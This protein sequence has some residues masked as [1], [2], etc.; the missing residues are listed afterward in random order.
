MSALDNHDPRR[1]DRFLMAEVSVA[2]HD[3]VHQIRV[4]NL[5]AGGMMGEG[6]VEVDR[7]SQINIRMP[8]LGQVAGTVAWTQGS[9]FGVAFAQDINPTDVYGEGPN[10]FDDGNPDTAGV[11]LD[12]RSETRLH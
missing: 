2:G 3:G 1:H 6:A 8:N 7:G 11:S 10:D 12:R 4:R 5:S 9:R